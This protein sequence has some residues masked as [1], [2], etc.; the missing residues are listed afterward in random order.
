MNL[1]FII[2]AS[3]WLFAAV[4]CLSIAAQNVLF[5]GMGAWAFLRL[6]QRR[7]PAFP[8]PLGLGLAFVAWALV[9]SLASPN[10]AHSLFTWKKW[11]LIFGALFV[12]DWT[13]SRAAL[14]AL[15]G[16]LLLFSALW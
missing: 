12:S 6:K 5:V 3:L 4:A 9:A 11:L 8:A 16:S 1:E 13:P 10:Q 14:K 15:L 2:F 7:L